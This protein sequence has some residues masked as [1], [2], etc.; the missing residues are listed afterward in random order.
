[1]QKFDLTKL[2]PFY[3]KIEAAC[4]AAFRA[5]AEP[6]PYGLLLELMDLPGLPMHCPPHHY[7]MPATLL[8]VAARKT[9]EPEDL[10][11]E[12]L[13]ECK[14]RAL[15]GPGRVL[16]LVRRLRRCRRHR[17]FYERF[18]KCRP[19]RPGLLGR[20]Q[21]RHRPGPAADCRGRRPRCCK[22]NSFIALQSAIASIE[23]SLGIQL[24]DPGKIVCKYHKENAECKKHACP[25]YPEEA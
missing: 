23:K 10:F 14:D 25:F 8:T 15:N 24:A 21:P 20:L 2:L 6:T 13:A 7:I 5:E 1:M 11:R 3:D 17:H 12:Q 16:R 22:R 9:G 19:P 4:L 18:Y